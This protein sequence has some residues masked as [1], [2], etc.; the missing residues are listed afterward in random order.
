LSTAT[1]TLTVPTSP[2][3]V[4]GTSVQLS[5]TGTDPT[6]LNQPLAYSWTVAGPQGASVL[7][8]G[9][10]PSA[11][12]SVT[13]TTDLMQATF[14]RA[15]T[16]VFQITATDASGMSNVQ[17]VTVDV[18]QVATQLDL[19]SANSTIMNGQTDTL[20]AS[21]LDQFG[22]PMSLTGISWSVSGIGGTVVANPSIAGQGTYTAPAS[23]GGS[24]TITAS[25]DGFNADIAIAVMVNSLQATAMSTGL[26]TLTWNADPN[27]QYFEVFRGTTAGFAPS[28]DNLI[29]DNLTEPGYGDASVSAN[30][31][32]YYE[33]FGISPSGTPTQLGQISTATPD[34]DEPIDPGQGPNSTPSGQPVSINAVGVNDLEILVSWVCTARNLD[35][36][37]IQ[38]SSTASL[39]DAVW[40]DAGTADMDPVVGTTNFNFIIRNGPNA[41]FLQEGVAYYIRIRSFNSAYN[42]GWSYDFSGTYV[43]IPNVNIDLGQDMIVICGGNSQSMSYLLQGVSVNPDGTLSGSGVS[44]GAI[45]VHL[46][47]EGYNAFLTADP[48]DGGAPYPGMPPYNGIATDGPEDVLNNDGSGWLYNEIQYELANRGIYN[49]G[50][51]GYSHGGGMIANISNLLYFLGTPFGTKVVFAATIDAVEYGTGPDSLMDP[52]NGSDVS[53]P[54]EYSPVTIWGGSGFNYWEP[55]GWLGLTGYLDR[56]C[57]VSM[58]GVSNYELDYDNH[59]TIA[60][61]NGVLLGIENDLDNVFYSLSF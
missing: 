44:V 50:L 45:W 53:S 3:T 13:V 60:L 56:I 59:S 43:A 54:L 29:A 8:N 28:T 35:G 20:T 41:S 52:Q 40:T 12:N 57:G 25:I 22:N 38:I 21:L 14:S 42:S 48:H 27:A 33:V 1:P 18:V 7:L 23:A 17:Q 36:F 34:Y 2:F 37:Q 55:N 9:A 6:G 61:D 32:Y 4:T 31:A 15:G 24:D 16:H 47:E 46:V 26:V 58:S 11:T 10:A 51:I 39:N 30:T 19:N 5:V 49:V